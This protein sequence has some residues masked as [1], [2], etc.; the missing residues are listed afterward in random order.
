M[1]KVYVEVWPLS[2][3]NMA[4]TTWE[5]VR[6]SPTGKSPL[7]VQ[8]RPSSARF[9]S[10]QLI[11]ATSKRKLTYTAGK[12]PIYTPVDWCKNLVNL[13]CFM[14]V[15]TSGQQQSS[16]NIGKGPF[17]LLLDNC[18]HKRTSMLSVWEW[19]TVSVQDSYIC[20]YTCRWRQSYPSVNKEVYY[21]TS[22]W[23][24]SWV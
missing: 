12:E 15:S 7:Q 24:V 16:Q 5:H 20:T 14:V 11:F 1:C 19:M 8:K 2:C 10:D 9:S 22:G 21:T 18:E 23:R 17:F 4:S 6:G 13:F 3:S